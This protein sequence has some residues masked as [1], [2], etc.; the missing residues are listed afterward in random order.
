MHVNAQYGSGLYTSDILETVVKL[1][2]NTED[3]RR[4]RAL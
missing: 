2:S 3:Y 4:K 1:A